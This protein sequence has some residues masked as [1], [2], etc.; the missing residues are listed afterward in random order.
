MSKTKHLVSLWTRFLPPADLLP[1]AVSLTKLA[2]K[3]ADEAG[4][5]TRKYRNHP[6]KFLCFHLLNING[7]SRQQTITF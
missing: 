2:W 3:Q 4:M 1:K 5:K 6:K 7:Y